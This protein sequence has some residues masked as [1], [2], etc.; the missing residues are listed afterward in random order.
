MFAQATKQ[1][2]AA[3]TG[4]LLILTAAACNVDVSSGD[5]GGAG[6]DDGTRTL[7]IGLGDDGPPTMV[8]NFNPFGT[9]KRHGVNYIYEPLMF[10][11]PVDGSETPFLATGYEISDDAT[12]V[13]FDLRDDVSW[14]DGETFDAADVVF[15]FRML[16]KHPAL[17]QS[18]LWDHIASVDGDAQTVTVELSEANTAAVSLIEQVL[19]VPEHVWSTVQDPVEYRNEDPVGT[20]PYTVGEF[21]PN[22][23]KLTKNPDYWQADEVAADEIVFPNRVS[24]LDIVNK[25][26]DWAYSF[27]PDPEQT[28][29]A[30][31][32]DHNHFWWP[33][34]A[35][36]SLF[37]NHAREPF[38]DV[39]FRRGLSLALNRQEISDKANQGWGSAASQTG[40][41]LPNQEDIL[42]PSIPDQGVIEQDQGAAQQEFEQAGMS[43]QDGRLLDDS[44]Q[45]VE[46]S[47]QIPN[48]YANQVQAA[49]VMK[50]QLSNAGIKLQVETPQAAAQQQNL[51]RGNYDM[52]LSWIGGTGIPYRDFSGLL[53]SRLTAPE[54]QEA[55]SNTIR[56]RNKKVDRIL[57]QIKVATEEQ[58]QAALARK[59]QQVMI[60][61]VPVIP[62]YYGGSWGLYST[63]SFTGWPSKDDPYALL[64][65][66]NTAGLMIVTHLE[67]A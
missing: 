25:D 27:L 44:G 31:D 38:D 6:D 57:D 62:I 36:T 28:W 49:Q 11:N 1:L 64:T 51:T 8:E 14:S 16:E 40:L 43:M 32:P 50:Q 9:D 21:T 55:R 26:Y 61:D 30:K 56:Y 2:V 53:D 45:Q 33:P 41:V 52:T 34:G 3:L 24:E 63:K 60:N 42:D 48:N 59:L 19:I 4:C 10:V 15:T 12:T 65:P 17:D 23:Y 29:V 66:Y 35:P 5:S 47:I 37:L 39:H 54:G 7:N 46:I 67:P 20:G 22:Q 13:T 18:G 58:Q